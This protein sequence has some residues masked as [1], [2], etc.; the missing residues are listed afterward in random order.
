MLFEEFNASEILFYKIITTLE[1]S[2]MYV[3]QLELRKIQQ[4]ILRGGEILVITDCRALSYF[5]AAQ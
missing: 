3:W 5:G 1:K 2:D 4:L